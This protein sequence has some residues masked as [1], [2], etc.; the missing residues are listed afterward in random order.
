MYVL[1][2]NVHSLGP[3]CWSKHNNWWGCIPLCD[4]HHSMF[5]LK[6]EMNKKGQIQYGL[7]WHSMRAVICPWVRCMLMQWC[8]YQVGWWAI[9]FFWVVCCSFVHWPGESVQL[10][11]SQ[12]L[13]DSFWSE[14]LFSLLCCIHLE[15]K[16]SV[17]LSCHHCHHHWLYQVVDLVIVTIFWVKV[18]ICCKVH[19]IVMGYICALLP[20]GVMYAG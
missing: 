6:E 13:C 19:I 17:L 14:S 5:R 10:Y 18:G 9:D 3:G 8:V 11:P 15:S 20:E 1:T 16:W 12:R 2:C 7:F 4:Q